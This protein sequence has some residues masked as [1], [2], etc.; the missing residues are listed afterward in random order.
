MEIVAQM[1]P[2]VGID[3][4]VKPTIDMV[5]FTVTTSNPRQTHIEYL[6]YP[7]EK[8]ID[9][10]LQFYSNEKRPLEEVY[11]R[12]NKVFIDGLSVEIVSVTA[13]RNYNP[14]TEFLHPYLYTITV[15]HGP[16]FEW[17]IHKRY[18][19]FHDLHKALAHYIERA[20]GRSISSLNKSDLSEKESNNDQSSSLSKKHED[21]PCFPTRNDRLSFI[22]QFTIE[23]RCKIL[24]NYLNK[25]LKHP[26][27]REHIATREFLEVSSLSFI[28]GLGVSIKEG[29]IAKRSIADIRGR[30]IFLRVPFICDKLRCHHAQTWFVLKDSYLVYMDSDSALI[31]FPMLID[32]AFSFKQG[33]QKTT[34]NNGI[35]IKNSQ[36]S[37]LIKFEKE[38]DRD[39]WFD[40]LRNV[41]R[42]SLFV[43]QILFYS[44]APRRQQQYAHWFINGQSYMEAV[45]K[46]ILAARE[47]IFIAG[48][49]LSPEVMLIR[50]CD[51]GSMR[52]VNLL[53]KRAEE[54][55]RV[56]V[57]LFKDPPLVGLNSQ[58]TKLKFMDQSP[59][60]KNIKVIR[61]PNHI[62]IPGTESS[63]LFS[64]HEKIVVI[65]QR[66]AFIGGIDLSWGRWDTDEHR[67]VDLC[68]ENITE[69]K[70]P[71]EKGD[72]LEEKVQN[73]EAAVGVTKKMAQNS[74]VGNIALSMQIPRDLFN[75]SKSDQEEKKLLLK[76]NQNQNVNGEKIK[77]NSHLAES[78]KV[79]DLRSV[80]TEAELEILADEENAAHQ[81]HKY[82]EQWKKII[83]TIRKKG[84]EESSDEDE[85]ISREPIDEKPTTIID[86]TPVV[87]KKYRYFMG[88][89]YAN[90]YDQD[91]ANLDK[92][93]EDSVDRKIFQRMPWHDEA[94]VV[95]GEAAR[96][97]ARHFIQ[98]WNIHKADKLR[99]N[100]FYPYILPKS[101]DDDQLFDSSMLSDILGEK[102]KP[103]RVD[104]QCVRSAAGWSCG[105]DFEESS[106]QN[107]YID[108]IENAQYFIYIENQF[109]VSI[110]TDT[111]ITNLIADAL[112]RRIIRA[113]THQEKFRVYV[114]LPLLPGFSNENAVQA[115]LYFIMRSIN[116]GETSLYQRL[117]RD[118]VYNPEDYI[119]FYGMRN[120]DI[121]MGKLVTEIIYV[122]SKLMIVDD[123]MCICGSANINDRSLLGDRDS[124]FCLFVKDDEM[125]D[126][127]LN[128]QK[129]KV[130]LFS[131][132]WRKKLFRQL[133]GIKNE[134]EM[135]VDD[136]CSD[137]F[138]EHFRRRAKYNAQIYEEV[139]NTLPTN[140]VRTFS[141]V[142]S[143]TH[144][145]KLRDTDPLTAHEKCKQIK[146]FVVEFPLE[147]LADDVLMPRWTTKE[148]LIQFRIEGFLCKINLF[149][150]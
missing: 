119:T 65:D 53:N 120:W 4:L 104:A 147:Y 79:T 144:Q 28:Q 150:L 56:Y 82:K 14:V 35:K 47:E 149:S 111:T 23:D 102:Q 37:I 67:L 117:I 58:Y 22:N 118:G 20:T 38:D 31:G 12:R 44:Y 76:S 73:E 78:S 77:N 87:D 74:I 64:H 3:S 36:R 114:V 97:C 41:T 99:F 106:I 137:E 108:M 2:S 29:A 95:S 142:N 113:A 96:D 75:Q 86:E 138:Y 83:K 141:E 27:F 109:F 84:N 45:A 59:T 90:P 140:R 91:F 46:A 6:P 17:I 133:L 5:R 66:I 107:A 15:R 122:H 121:L 123:R 130:G 39:T 55:I 110:A 105:I 128:G 125:I 1:D 70:L 51:D 93:D 50:P 100:E 63:F 7:D 60:K 134:E 115:V 19:H 57:L 145:S 94:L 61:H 16:V 48:W 126:S 42:K 24:Q 116:K 9:E 88:K 8:F 92:F 18:K 143:Y 101:Y 80:L 136:P 129:Q 71:N 139:F 98:R 43:E 54:G 21:Q 13:V 52:L 26:K 25:V 124:E 103:M 40:C 146:G 89:D 68:D 33:Y 69:L 30:S 34:T 127:Q 132:T 135:S 148:G 10:S 112:Y 49:F 11:L 62:V 81:R 131:S 85:E 72:Q 32:K